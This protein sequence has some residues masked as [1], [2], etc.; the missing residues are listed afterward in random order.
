MDKIEHR[1]II[2]FLTKEGENASNIHQ[3]LVNVYHDTAPAYSTVAKWTA[4]FK[5]GRLS[6][7]DDERPGRPVEVINDEICARTEQLV[8]SDRRIKIIQI[9]TELRISCGSVWTILHEKL[10][11][12]KVCARWV[13]RMLTPLQKVSRVDVCRDLLELYNDNKE[14]FSFRFVTGDETWIHFWDPETKQESMHWKH[15]D[16]PPPKKFR[17]Q[18]SAGKVMATI[19]W[20]FKG[21][22]HI[23]YMPHNTT[24]TGQYYAGLLGRLRESIKN[25]RRGKLTRGPLL[26]HDN[27][28]VHMSHVAQGAVREHGFQQLPHPPYSPDLAP[29]DFFLFRHLKK[30]LRGRRF[31]DDEEV[32]TAAEQWFQDQPEMFYS[33]SLNELCHRWQKCIDIRGDYVEK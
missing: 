24:I 23:D 10:G 8:M 2:K 17:T 26:L 1:A 9:A 22:I 16:S 32:H 6:I 14:D 28:P 15:R 21:V 30:A 18:P 31:L 5:R 27:A 11:M 20:D 7:K 13:P 33:G 3:R 19:F 4:E 12:S 29:S 25:K